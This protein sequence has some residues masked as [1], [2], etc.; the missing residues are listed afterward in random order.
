MRESFQPVN[1]TDDVGQPR[2]TGPRHR[3]MGAV[4]RSETIGQR[5]G[6][7][8]CALQTLTDAQII[9]TSESDPSRFGEIFDRHFP[10]IHRYVNRRVGREL[11]DDLA[12]ETFSV[13]FRNR[14]RFDPTREDAGP[15]LY[16]IAANLLRDHRRNERDGSWP[17]RRPG[18]IRSRTAASMPRMHGSMQAQRG[19]PWPERWLD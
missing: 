8:G 15:W 7:E 1:A 17:M 12:A 16:G 9:S 4:N 18:W 13:A 14:A 11:A 5:L 3:K 10:A 6:E 19:R 2:D